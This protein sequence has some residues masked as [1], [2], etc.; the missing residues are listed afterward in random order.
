MKKIVS[1]FISILLFPVAYA[2]SEHE[3]ASVSAKE[4]HKVEKCVDLACVR[5]Q[6]D[7]VNK[8]II[9][10]LAKRME[11]VNQAGDIKLKNNI[12]SAYD[13]KRADLVVNTAEEIGK[14]NGLPDGFTKS[15]FQVIV[16]KSAENEQK[17]MDQ[18]KVK[19]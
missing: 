12:A 19:K 2:C 11:Y 3:Q 14:K 1:A 7:K 17:N 16:D 8:E 4:Q 13:K 5:T 10:L 6:I 18:S 15:V 9:A